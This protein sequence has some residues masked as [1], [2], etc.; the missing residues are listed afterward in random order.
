MFPMEEKQSCQFIEYNK[1][2]TITKVAEN[3]CYCI[4]SSWANMYVK[5]MEYFW[6]DIPSVIKLK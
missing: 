1:Y 5:T 3:W 6:W 4:Q 2:V